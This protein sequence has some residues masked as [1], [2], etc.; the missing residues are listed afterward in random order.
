MSIKKETVGYFKK[1]SPGKDT[2]SARH[3]FIEM[4][5]NKT[6]FAK[7]K[8]IKIMA[9]GKLRSGDELDKMLCYADD[10]LL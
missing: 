9:S 4:L 8:N 7:S 3:S 5:Q 6:F 2:K 10:N 1:W